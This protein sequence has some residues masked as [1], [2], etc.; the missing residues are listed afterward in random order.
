MMLTRFTRL[1]CLPPSLVPTECFVTVNISITTI[2]RPITVFEFLEGF[3]NAGVDY[4]FSISEL[5]L[6]M[7]IALY[8]YTHLH[9]H[10]VNDSYPVLFSWHTVERPAQPGQALQSALKPKPPGGHDRFSIALHRFKGLAH[11]FLPSYLPTYT[12]MT[13]LSWGRC[14][15]CCNA[16]ACCITQTCIL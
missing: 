3:W 1:H 14:C 8:W 13:N 16:T 12:S 9:V 2:N 5:T 6:L 7:W 11:S 4:L 15:E 10:A